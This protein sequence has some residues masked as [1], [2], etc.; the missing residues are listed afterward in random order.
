[1]EKIKAKLYQIL[2]WSEKYSQ[3]DM[4]YLARGGTWLTANGIITSL[5]IFLSAVA[6]A[7]LLP[8]ETYGTYKYIL[9][10]ASLFSVATL[11][12][13]TAAVAQAVARHYEGVLV[14][15]IKTRI[16]WGILAALASLGMAGYYFLNNNITLTFSFLLTAAFLPFMDSFMTYDSFLQGRKLFRESSIYGI[17]SQTVAAALVILTLFL[18]K[19]L[20]IILLVYF[21][22]WTLIRFLCLQLTLGKFKPNKEYN[23]KTISYGKHFSAVNVIS[24]II[25]SFDNIIIFHFI[26]AAELAVYSFAILPIF[27]LKTFSNTFATLAMPKF[28]QRPLQ[29]I[30]EVLG[31]RIRFLFFLGLGV[32][33]IYIIIAPFA[34]RIFFPKYIDSVFLSQIFSLY[35]AVL[36]VQSIFHS[37]LNSKLTAIPKK[38]LYLWN[39][40]S[41]ISIFLMFFFV[42]PWGVLGVI[43]AK[44][45]SSPLVIGVSLII[46]RKIN[47]P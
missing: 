45:I 43:L 37:I 38:F 17:V 22:S 3:T 18:T 25:D 27:Q 4:V 11:S 6:F 46:W 44:L 34:F 1:M 36:L 23:P 21:T 15:A 31:K 5:S 39:I 9:S 12:G 8:K 35:L 42:Q 29:E 33:L 30:K 24:I 13:M 14:P 32:S 2:R 47:A 7:N 20:F 28:A 10:L 41:V 16:R 26:G 19:N 40:P